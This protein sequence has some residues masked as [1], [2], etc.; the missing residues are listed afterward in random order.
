MDNKILFISNEQ[1]LNVWV[2]KDE[3]N[4]LLSSFLKG[5]FCNAKIPA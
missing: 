1:N 2:S 5:V 4:V 3:K